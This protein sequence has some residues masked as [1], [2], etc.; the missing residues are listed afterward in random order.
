M[1]TAAFARFRPDDEET[2]D[3]GPVENRFVDEADVIEELDRLD[4]LGRPDDD[5]GMLRGTA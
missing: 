3:R 1:A 5:L 2:D 4:A